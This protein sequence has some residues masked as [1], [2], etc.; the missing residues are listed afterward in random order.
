MTYTG[1]CDVIVEV[2]EVL[3]FDVM[4]EVLINWLYERGFSAQKR[5][6]VSD[7]LTQNQQNILYHQKDQKQS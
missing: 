3:V 1:V 6:I 5:I 2:L 4:V 7:N